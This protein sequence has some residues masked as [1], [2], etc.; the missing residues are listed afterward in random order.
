[1]DQEA[2]AL[3]AEEL[4]QLCSN[5]SKRE[6]NL[7]SL[8]FEQIRGNHPS[9]QGLKLNLLRHSG[10]KVHSLRS[11]LLHSNEAA[12]KYGQAVELLLQTQE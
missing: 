9:L 4:L 1:M 6:L 8:R 11:D 10:V 7:P 2:Q 3:Q 5:E 12:L